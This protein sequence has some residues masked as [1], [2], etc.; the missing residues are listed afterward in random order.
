MYGLYE[1]YEGSGGYN[2]PEGD[3]AELNTLIIDGGHSY[4]ACKLA[5][6]NREG[7]IVLPLAQSVV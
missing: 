4:G 7:N 5:F 3:Y 6:D 1:N 2:Q